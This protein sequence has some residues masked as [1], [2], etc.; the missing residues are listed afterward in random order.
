MCDLC[1]SSGSLPHGPAAPVRTSGV[2]KQLFRNVAFWQGMGFVMLVS[3][4]WVNETLDLTHLLFQ[5]QS[6]PNDWLGASVLTVGILI[7]AFVTVAHTYVLQRRI[8][9]GIIIVCSYC[10]KVKIEETSWERME[11]FLA[12]KTRARFSHGI[13][14]ACYHELQRGM[15]EEKSEPVPAPPAKER[16]K[17]AAPVPAPASAAAVRRPPAL[18]AAA[19]LAG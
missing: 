4:V 5:R 2:V 11:H 9:E 7:I 13:C 17:E 1:D 19:K 3:L 18:V 14:P 6:T 15:A 8:L 10:S 16:V 12:G